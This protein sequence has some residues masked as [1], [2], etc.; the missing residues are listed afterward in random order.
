[1]VESRR[2]ALAHFKAEADWQP[3]WEN[4]FAAV[5]RIPDETVTLEARGDTGMVGILVY[6]PALQWIV[7]LIVKKNHR[8]RGV[9]SRLLD[10]LVAGA[11]EE[12]FPIKIV[13]VDSGDQ[14]MIRLLTSRGFR[15]YT[16]QYEMAMDI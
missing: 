13:N 1:M 15:V 12:A 14:G 11:P 9:A 3:S 7:S 16:R 10:R 6:Y 4:S 8:R 5:S 2:D